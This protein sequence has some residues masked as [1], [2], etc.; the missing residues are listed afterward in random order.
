MIDWLIATLKSKPELVIFLA[1]AGG[2][3][4][5]KLKLGGFSLGSVTG[6]LLVGVLIGQIGIDVS[7]QVKSIFFT[8]FLFAV[9]YSV[10]PQFVRGI[11]KDG[12]PQ[13]IFAVVISVLCLICPVVIAK[14][15]G[16]NVAQAVGFFAG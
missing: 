13:A 12:V 1:L 4:I 2:Y 3:F 15:A 5:G 6:T 14:I 10:G 7:P 9:G 11:A 16:Y 8:M